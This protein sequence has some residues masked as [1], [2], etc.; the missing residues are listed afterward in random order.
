M[1]KKVLL[2]SSIGNA[3][4]FFDFTLYGAF[5]S[6]IA[7]NFFPAENQT[8]SL[9]MALGVFGVGFIMRPV[10]ALFFGYFGDR[11]GRKKALSYSVFLMGMPTFIIGIL[12]NY[13][14]IGI[15]A[16]IIILSGRLIQ[17]LCLGGEYNGAAIFAIEH[18]QK[19][20]GLTGGIITGS[21]VAGAFLATASGALT[22]LPDMPDWSWR[23]PFLFGIVV[24]IIGYYIRKN[25]LE[26]PDFINDTSKSKIP[27]LEVI[28]SRKR[29]CFLS[30]CFGGLNGALSY[31]LFAF[32]N[33]YLS[34]YLNFSLATA[35]EVNLFGL[36]A[37][38]VGSPL[39]GMLY[40]KFPNFSCLRIISYTL[41]F[42]LIPI[43]WL[44]SSELYLLVVLGQIFLTSTRR[45]KRIIH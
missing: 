25:L 15:A 13:D 8:A 30:F 11:F 34:R 27:I 6:I 22:Q 19:K 4:E 33:I 24:S 35:M 18:S 2:A 16:S 12:P 41:F 36:L 5:L 20:P 17:G 21:C 7:E 26:S 37:F 32:L 38:M 45:K 31:T 14:Q 3:L 9:L 44:L 28:S 43:F 29:S 1:K 39:L 42:S 40:D 23:I 10:G